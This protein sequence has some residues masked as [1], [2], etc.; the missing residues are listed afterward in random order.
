MAHLAKTTMNS[1]VAWLRYFFQMG[2]LL[3]GSM[4][5]VEDPTQIKAQLDDVHI[6]ISIKA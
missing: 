5:N 4:I 6:L 2:G 1:F 3:F